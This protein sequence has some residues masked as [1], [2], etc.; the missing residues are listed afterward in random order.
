M[1]YLIFMTLWVFGIMTSF[2]HATSF[3]L[4]ADA[5][6]ETFDTKPAICLPVNA[7]EEFPVGWVSLSESYVRNPASWAVSL[8]DGGNPL[9]LKPGECIVF[10][11]IPSGYELDNNVRSGFLTLENNKT[12]VFRLSG[13][14]KTRDTYA[15]VF[16]TG[17]KMKGGF[18]FHQYSREADGGQ[19]MPECDA[20]RN[21]G[22]YDHSTTG[23]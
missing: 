16:C 6:I 17:S 1:A 20:K 10:G 12:Y 22:E 2:V 7:K 13:A 18:E 21:G 9:I 3:G 4:M 11:E 14:Y 23:K 8:K 5:N 19:V 15:A